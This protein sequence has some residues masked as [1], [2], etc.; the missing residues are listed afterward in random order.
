MNGIEILNQ[1]ETT[2]S[3][4]VWDWNSFWLAFSLVFLIGTGI[5]TLIGMTYKDLFTG[6]IAGA[7]VSTFFGL[8]VGT[9]MGTNPSDKTTT[10]YQITISEETP[11]L[12]FYNK[13]E[14][15]KQEGKIFTVTEKEKNEGN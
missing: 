4:F 7:I 12:D 3:I 15:V 11:M 8:F 2:S 14:I 13:Y 5:A 1:Y 9:I 6:I 10:M